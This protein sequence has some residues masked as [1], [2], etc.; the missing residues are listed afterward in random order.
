MDAKL[1]FAHFA[2]LRSAI[3]SETEM[4][5][6]FVTFPA[7]VKFFFRKNWISEACLYPFSNRA[8]LGVTELAD[9]VVL[10]WF[11]FNSVR[12]LFSQQMTVEKQSAFQSKCLYLKCDA[13]EN[14]YSCS[15]SLSNANLFRWLFLGALPGA[16][17]RLPPDWRRRTSFWEQLQISQIRFPQKLNSK[18]YRG[19]DCLWDNHLPETTTAADYQKTIVFW[20]DRPHFQII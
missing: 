16:S 3:F 1:R 13:A 5:N 7:R 4:D 8:L 19:A 17:V 2:S 20:S 6:L 14:Q 18:S 9:L 12:L 10:G 11:V 15:E